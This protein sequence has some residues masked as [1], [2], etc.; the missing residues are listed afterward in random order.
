[1]KNG[2]NFWPFCMQQR[3]SL[4]EP[5]GGVVFT[6]AVLECVCASVCVQASGFCTGTPLPSKHRQTFEKPNL[7]FDGS[8]LRD[9]SLSLFIIVLLV[10]FMYELREEQRTAV[11]KHL[12][13][14]WEHMQQESRQKGKS[15]FR[16]C[17]C[18]C[19]NDREGCSC[20]WSGEA[21]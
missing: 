2:I 10:S 1:M 17:M 14:S 13:S 11:D 5:C 18:A 20:M 7:Q 12:Y 8:R 15:R 21:F 19:M 3:P 9:T 4:T 6:V 16:L